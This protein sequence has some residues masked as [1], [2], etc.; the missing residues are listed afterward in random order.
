[1]FF[2]KEV[3]RVLIKNGLAVERLEDM[4]GHFALAEPVDGVLVA[5][6]IIPQND[7][8]AIG[9]L[10]YD[11]NKNENP[12]GAVVI[13]GFINEG[14]LETEPANTAKTALSGIVFMKD[15]KPD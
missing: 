7:E 6:T 12:N 4:L 14:K 13:H 3:E 8:T 5:G 9:I 2:E 1:M 11:V 15:G 10:L